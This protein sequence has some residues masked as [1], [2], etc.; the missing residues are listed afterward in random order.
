MF[1][2][3]DQRGIHCLDLLFGWSLLMQEVKEVT[4]DAR[5]F[6]LRLDTIAVVSEVI[7]VREHRRKRCEKSLGDF[8]LLVKRCLRLQTPESGAARSQD[9][10][11]MGGCGKL[12]QRRPQG[13]GKSSL[14]PEP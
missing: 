2:I 13:D 12:L 14:T 3:E 11:R 7:P 5:I 4:S 8:V 10:H 9:V 1:S 6:S